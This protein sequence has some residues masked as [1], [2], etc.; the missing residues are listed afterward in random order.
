MRKNYSRL[1]GAGGVVAELIRVV[2][3]ATIVGGV[4]EVKDVS[5]LCSLV[6][7]EALSSILVDCSY[8]SCVG[9]CHCG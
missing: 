6:G 4:V 2:A 8:N 9:G 7:A 1:P 5:S 3:H